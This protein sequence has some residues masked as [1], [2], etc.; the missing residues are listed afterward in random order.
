[1]KKLL[2]VLLSVLM[3]SGCISIA[4]SAAQDAASGL[5]AA[6]HE[7]AL[8]HGIVSLGT[9]VN[10]SY[11]ASNRSTEQNFDAA[12]AALVKG[13]EDYESEVSIAQYHIT[14][15]RVDDLL[16]GL[17]YDNPQLFYLDSMIE[18]GYDEN[19]NM[20]LNIWLYY[21]MPYK[22]VPAA[23]I[24]FDNAVDEIYNQAKSFGSDQKKMLAV[25]EALVLQCEYD[26]AALDPDTPYGF[27][28]N[29]YGCLVEKKAVCQGYAL[30][31]KYV[32]NKLGIDCIPVVSRE[33]NHM[34]NMVRLGSKWY[35]VDATWD[36]PVPDTIGY[37]AHDY[38][39]KSD[40]AM[41]AG[42][43]P[44][45]GW[46]APYQASDSTYDNSFW[47]GVC[48]AILPLEGTYYY[49]TPDNKLIGRNIQ[50]GDTREMPFV[51]DEWD[52]WGE[53]GYV[54]DGTFA[55]IAV[56]NGKIYFNTSR[57][58]YSVAPNDSEP[59][60][61]YTP[62]SLQGAIYGIKFI[63]GKLAYQVQKTPD[64]TGK[65][66]FTDIMLKNDPTKVQPYAKGDPTGD[67]NIKIDDV[68]LIQKSLVR[69]LTL[70]EK[71]KNAADVNND[72][73]IS[74][75]DVVMI[76]KLIAG[77]IGSFDAAA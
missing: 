7:E 66:Y 45:T 21:I 6:S 39:L 48:S 41:K 44:H 18:Y 30:A 47:S 12:L 35:H 42:D 64:G 40:K 2:C 50:S 10:A 51:P 4:A 76:Q 24:Q 5:R 73:D 19:T 11:H 15:D 20:L 32:L 23:R 67:G 61:V 52:V 69:M 60:L 70:D 27:T 75:R 55:T 57:G 3:L 33:M 25:H 17:L 63:D 28:F 14:A 56:G 46:T 43:Y 65:I 1:M 72:G 53:D 8:G 26:E 74:V 77:Q 16:T 29:A 59:E 71:Q 13:A 58:I 49:V 31:Y 9:S 38:F 36:D 37:V 22:E 68:L 54:W 62:S 34:W